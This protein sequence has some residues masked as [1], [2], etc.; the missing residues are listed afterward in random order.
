MNK[1]IPQATCNQWSLTSKTS[2]QLKGK[3]NIYLSI[4]SD[5]FVTFEGQSL[6]WFLVLNMMVG[7]E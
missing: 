1:I 6:K 2:C 3:K 7:K 4:V 5:H